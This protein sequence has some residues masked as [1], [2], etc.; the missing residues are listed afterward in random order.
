[1]INYDVKNR[2]TG[3]VQ[4]TAEIEADETDGRSWKLR[5]AT[6]WAI[7][8]K[9]NLSGA[10]LSGADLS[11]ADLS[12]ANLSGANLSGADLSGANLSGANL[13]RAELRRANLSGANLSGAPKV[14]NIHQKVAAAVKGGDRLCMDVWHHPCG[15][16][17]C[18]A[19]WVVTLAGEDGA[20]LEDK[21]GT[22]AAAAAIYMAS[23]PEI[24]KIPDF[25]A[26]N[27]EALEDI[28]ACAEREKV[29]AS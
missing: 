2:W 12:G 25:Y 5:L 10:D 19:G 17:H 13:R 6:Q 15:T 16:K 26:S 29:R 7:K 8:N 27:E 28:L 11:G 22:A 20:K 21:I 14:E 1:M 3:D 18:R 24:K 9:A 4:F 23:D